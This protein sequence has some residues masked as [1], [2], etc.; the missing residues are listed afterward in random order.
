MIPLRMAT[1]AVA[2]VVVC[3]VGGEA[4]RI[5]TE[6]EKPHPWPGGVVLPVDTRIKSLGPAKRTVHG[7]PLDEM[8]RRMYEPKEWAKLKAK[9]DKMEQKKSLL[10]KM[11][12]TKQ[13]HR[14]Y[15]GPPLPRGYKAPPNCPTFPFCWQIPEAPAFG[16]PP[17][18]DAKAGV[19]PGMGEKGN[20]GKPKDVVVI[21]A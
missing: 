13:G 8:I 2:F 10:P 3:V 17:V 9:M 1:I 5:E 20:G 15:K 16:P 6:M 21:N 19:A 18:Q 14:V 7:Q 4:V 11:S 12:K